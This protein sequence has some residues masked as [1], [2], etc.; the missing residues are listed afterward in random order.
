MVHVSEGGREKGRRIHDGKEESSPSDQLDSDIVEHV[1]QEN[2][3]VW[4]V[5]LGVDIT[6]FQE[7][8]ESVHSISQSISH[9]VLLTTSS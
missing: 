4:N 6:E 1:A 8:V 2:G 5:E 9:F 3:T 7:S